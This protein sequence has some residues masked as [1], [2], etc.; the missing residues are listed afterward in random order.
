MIHHSTHI[1]SIVL[2]LLIGTV[3]VEFSAQHPAKTTQLEAEGFFT[4]DQA[5]G[6]WWFIDPEGNPFFSLGLNHIDPASLRYPENIHIWEKKYHGSTTEWLEKSVKTNLEEW[7]FNT[8]GWEQ[9]VT[10][11]QWQHSRSFTNDEL[12]IFRDNS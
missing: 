11:R 3:S 8:M 9:E 4:L 2:M 5:D 10:V 1:A 12:P 7:G 6:K